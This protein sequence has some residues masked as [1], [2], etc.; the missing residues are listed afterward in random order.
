[1]FCQITPI[2]LLSL[3]LE[4]VQISFPSYQGPDHEQLRKSQADSPFL[5]HESIKTIH[6]QWIHPKLFR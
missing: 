1:M 3:G 6:Q 4:S 2:Q 5:T